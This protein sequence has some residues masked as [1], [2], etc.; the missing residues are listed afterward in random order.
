V[1]LALVASLGGCSG[2]Q[3]RPIAPMQWTGAANAP[4]GPA[5][6]PVVRKRCG[7]HADFG[8][9]SA[10]SWVEDRQQRLGNFISPRAD[11]GRLSRI[12]KKT[13]NL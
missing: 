10:A 4:K 5:V 12:S 6:S 7:S 13:R 2:S 8:S 11:L 9:Q 1:L 3:A